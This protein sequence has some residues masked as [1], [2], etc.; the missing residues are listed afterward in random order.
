[1]HV[2][3]CYTTSSILGDDRGLSAHTVGIGRTLQ[4]RSEVSGL[5]L[6]PALT[7]GFHLPGLRRWRAGAPSRSVALR[8]VRSG[9]FGAGGNDFPG[10]QAALGGL[11]PGNVAGD[12]PEKWSQC[13]GFAE[14]AGF[15]Q[16]QNRLVAAAQVAS[17]DGQ[18]GTG[19][20]ERSGR[21]ACWGAEESGV[22]G[23][24]AVNKALVLVAAQAD[25]KGIGRIR[26][27]HIPDTDRGTLHGFIV[28]SI[29]P[30]SAVVTDGLQACRELEDDILRP[31][32]SKTSARR[33]R[34]FVTPGASGYFAVQTLVAGHSPRCNCSSSISK[35]IWT[36]S[37]SAST[38]ASQPREENCSAVWL[39]RRFRFR[40]FHTIRSRITSCSGIRCHVHSPIPR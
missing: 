35:I 31:S 24:R 4:R 8:P 34:A 16:L 10:Q 23:R 13:A 28:Q 15:G 3:P 11:V 40:R 22:R 1:M 21:K 33:R 36:S 37:R 5:S 6:R 27:R 2:T 12:F 25:G 38:G 9:N 20:L 18:T 29:E 7:A 32:N 14:S 17:G 30:G 26:L 39:N 19:S